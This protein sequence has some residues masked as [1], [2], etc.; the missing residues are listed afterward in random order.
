MRVILT[1]LS[2][3]I[4]IF[5]LLNIKTTQYVS[6]CGFIYGLVAPVNLRSTTVLTLCLTVLCRCEH[7]EPTVLRAVLVQR[8]REPDARRTSLQARSSAQGLEAALV[9]PR[10]HQTPTALLRR[11]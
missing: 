9:C 5:I 11:R 2:F 1:F 3:T 8:G 10:L 7:N 6:S 4:I